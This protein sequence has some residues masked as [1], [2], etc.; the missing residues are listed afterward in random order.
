ME[1][2][3]ISTPE[4]EKVLPILQDAI[5]RQKRLLSQS[6]ARDWGQVFTLA[7]QRRRKNRRMAGSPQPAVPPV[8]FSLEWRQDRLLSPKTPHFS[9]LSS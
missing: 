8:A 1:K 6:L 4:P 2:I 3:E 9:P 7:F 5:E